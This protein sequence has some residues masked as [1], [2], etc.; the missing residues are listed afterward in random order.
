MLTESLVRS[1]AQKF[2]HYYSGVRARKP[3]VLELVFLE[4]AISIAR[5]FPGRQ[6]IDTT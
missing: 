5:Q 2:H 1:V 4:R 3:K 6:R